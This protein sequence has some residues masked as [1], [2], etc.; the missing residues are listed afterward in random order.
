MSRPSLFLDRDGTINQMVY[1]ETHGLVDSPR[2]A[3]QVQ[4]IPGVADCMKWARGRG[5]L[6]VVVTN[7]PGLAKGT[8]SEEGLAE[9]HDALSAQLADAGASWDAI[10]HC[11]HHPVGAPHG[12]QEY[13]QTC[14]CRKPRP[15]LLLQAMEDFD[16]DVSNSWMIGDGLNDVQAGN[17]AGCKT[18]FFGELKPY[19]ADQIQKLEDAQPHYTASNWSQVQDILTTDYRH[20][21]LSSSSQDKN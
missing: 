21:V 5:F 3:S 18:I 13:I 19:H 7:Q 6:I 2:N 11:P 12:I 17:R 10:Y 20:V 4:L 9:V 14:D 16:I 8:L 15:G 1:D